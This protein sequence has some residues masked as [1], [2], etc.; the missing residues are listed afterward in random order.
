MR[1]VI[2]CLALLVSAQAY[3]QHNQRLQ[4]FAGEFFAWR[5]ATQPASGDDIPRVERP[6]GW[7][8]DFSPQAL[9]R[10][11][12]RYVEFA[13]RLRAI[14]KVGWTRADSVDYLLLR[15]AI[16]RVNWELNVLRLPYRDPGFYV[17]QTL[18]S[19]YELLLIHS[20]MTPKRARNIILRLESIPATVEHAK[21]NL[22][23]PVA[24]FAD[25]ALANLR[26]IG[27][28]LAVTAAALK[29]TMPQSLRQRLDNATEAAAEA[30][31]DY[32]HWIQAQRSNMT[33]EFS[34]GRQGYSY[35]LKNVA[36]I[37]Y[38][39]EQLLR[40]GR[41]E[42]NRAVAFDTYERVR[43][44][45]LPRAKLFASVAE[46]IEQL[47]KDELAIRK[48]LEERNIMS[49]PDWVRHYRFEKMPSR[50]APLAFLGVTDD[51]TSASRLDEDAVRYIPE[52]SP[53]LPFFFRT[54]A[55]DPRP[56]M[57]H[58]GIPGHYFQL[59]R[60]WANP[61]PIRRHY[62]DSGANEGIGFYVEELL[63]QFGLFDDSPHTR[64]IIY[65][66]MRLR[67]LRVDVDINLGL[68]NYG[69]EEAARYLASTV[70]MDKNR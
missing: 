52:P 59:A 49:V 69:I 32:A 43:N 55:Q 28:K 68:G 21:Q 65:R 8:P 39:P 63:L 5:A 53:D 26:D 38:T 22:V 51:L 18:G 27:K 41:L 29:E 15:A 16:E 7:T 50:L 33:A 24:P 66:F 17:A 70:P 58:E 61:D 25:I 67:A 23:D 31:E 47:R 37:P 6:D 57:V 2:L 42:W 14:P 56:L 46:E 40:M 35:F 3:A 19:V 13:E 45:A 9:E 62:I 1:H 36:L 44:A 20:A 30:L 4:D 11:K 48:F 64:E 10:Y 54:A 34:V 12:A 60:S